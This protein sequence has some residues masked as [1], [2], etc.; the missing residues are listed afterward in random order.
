MIIIIKRNLVAKQN[1]LKRR[2]VG[3]FATTIHFF[4]G[5]ENLQRLYH[6][7]SL[8]GQLEDSQRLHH[9]SPLFRLSIRLTE[10]F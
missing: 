9:G 5:R 8:F 2:R 1:F 3:G 6:D 7:S 4:G 10:A